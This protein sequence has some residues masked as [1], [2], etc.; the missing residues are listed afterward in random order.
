MFRSSQA[1]PLSGMSALKTEDLTVLD[2]MSVLKFPSRED[3]G[4]NWLRKLPMNWLEPSDDRRVVV[5]VS[6]IR[7]TDKS[8]YKG[9]VFFNPGVSD[10]AWNFRQLG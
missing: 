2:L 9:P 5:A 6:R 8:N 10:I 4:A 1:E 3:D 7:A